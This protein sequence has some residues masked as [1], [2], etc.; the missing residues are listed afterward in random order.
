MLLEHHAKDVLGS[1]GF[2]VPEGVLATAPG[3]RIG[4]PLMV[5]AQVPVGGR[6][7]AGGILRVADDAALGEALARVMAMTIK[8]HPVRACRLERPIAFAQECYLSLIVD[9][10]AG[11]VKVMMSAEGGVDI[12]DPALRGKILSQVAGP[13]LAS[14]ET[15]IA[16][17]A[18][19]LPLAARGAMREA[20]LA[21]AR[22][23]FAFEALLI[24]INPL[25]VRADGS[26]VAGDVKFAVDE[27]ALPRQDAL[28]AIVEGNA[29]LYP[30]AAVKFARGFDFVVL[31]PDGDIGLVTTGAGLSLQLIDELVA[32]GHRPFNFCD[33]RTGGFKGDPGR[34]VEVFRWIAAAPRIRSVLM[35][36]FAGMTD[37]GELAKLLLAALDQVPQL[38][39]RPITARL[40]GNGLAEAQAILAAAG[41][42]IAVETDLERAIAR[43]VAAI[44]PAP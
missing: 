2:P 9:A 8:G 14:V 13:D 23:F 28:R 21:M 33:I 39:G 34:L 18:A 42:P 11:G 43:A 29:R 36:F 16:E 4:F 31:D 44:G 10:N 5:K 27:N 15:A 17:L 38:K 3:H 20:A 6:G 41:S 40:I 19:R 25:F 32:R 24:E 12:E 35:N 37:L 22:N 30:E 26:W 7:K 1:V